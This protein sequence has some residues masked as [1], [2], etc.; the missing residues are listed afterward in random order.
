MDRLEKIRGLCMA[1]PEVTEEV[2]WGT[3]VNFRVRK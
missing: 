1:L 3:D 2:T